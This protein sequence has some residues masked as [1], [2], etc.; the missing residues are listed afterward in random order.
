[1]LLTDILRNADGE[2][3]ATPPSFPGPH[4]LRQI[5]SLDG[6]MSIPQTVLRHG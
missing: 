4:V 6:A 1:M 2:A 3:L 5:V